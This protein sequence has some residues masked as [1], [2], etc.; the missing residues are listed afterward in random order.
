MDV[1]FSNFPLGSNQRREPTP[2]RIIQNVVESRYFS[3]AHFLGVFFVLFFNI[4]SSWYFHWP[5]SPTTLRGAFLLHQ[6]GAHVW[7]QQAVLDA[8]SPLRC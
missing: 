2:W 1:V 8:L 4:S 6:E 7:Q 3:P 5:P